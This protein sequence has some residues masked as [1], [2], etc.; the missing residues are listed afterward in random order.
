MVKRWIQRFDLKRLE[1]L[2][3]RI[4]NVLFDAQDQYLETT[5]NEVIKRLEE[6]QMTVRFAGTNYLLHC[7]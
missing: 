4:T 3:S 5:K 6:K 7:A 1:K 2:P